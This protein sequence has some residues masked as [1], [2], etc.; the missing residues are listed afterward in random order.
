MVPTPEVAAARGGMYPLAISPFHQ[1]MVSA[2]W[3]ES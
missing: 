2:N 3:G 1:L